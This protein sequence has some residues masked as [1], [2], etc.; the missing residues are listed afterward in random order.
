[1]YTTERL[2]SKILNNDICRIITLKKLLLSIHEYI[3]MLGLVLIITKPNGSLLLRHKPMYRVENTSNVCLQPNNFTKEDM[4]RAMLHYLRSLYTVDIYV[5][6]M[7][8]YCNSQH[9]SL[10]GLGNPRCFTVTLTRWIVR[11]HSRFA[12]VTLG[13]SRTSWN[14]VE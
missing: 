14:G 1:M 9:N 2:A 8:I 6:I 13:L 7:W 11:W 3:S 5:V 12:G 4:F 10:R